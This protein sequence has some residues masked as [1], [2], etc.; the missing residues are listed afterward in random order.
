MHLRFVLNF[1]GLFFFCFSLIPDNIIVCVWRGTLDKVAG[2]RLR[3]GRR[4]VGV[5]M[6]NELLK[7]V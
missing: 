3:T 5:D 6:A 7:T 2:L 4:S 1:L